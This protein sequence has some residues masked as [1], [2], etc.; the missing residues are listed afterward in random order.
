[1]LLL[2]TLNPPALSSPRYRLG[3]RPQAAPPAA[4][5]E[6]GS[7]ASTPT[8]APSSA[9]AATHPASLPHSDSS[10]G[11]QRHGPNPPTSDPTLGRHAPRYPGGPHRMLPTTCSRR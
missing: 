10:P 9:A 3:R 6:P 7:P 8:H 5:V 2:A 1:M 11:P 4:P